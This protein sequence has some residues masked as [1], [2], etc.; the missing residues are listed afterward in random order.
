MGE[1]RVREKPKKDI[2]AL[3]RCT[4]EGVNYSL[5]CLDCRRRGIRRQYLGETSRSGHQRFKEHMREIYGGQIKHPMTLHFMEEHQGE[6][7]EVMFRILS[8]HRTPLDR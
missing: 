5:E 6:I 1:G 7:Q 3:S 4:V 8:K 2:I